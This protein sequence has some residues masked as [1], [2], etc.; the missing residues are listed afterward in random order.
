[1]STVHLCRPHADPR[2]MRGQVVPA[3]AP[4][5]IARLGLFIVQVEPLMGRINIST[6]RAVKLAA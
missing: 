3:L 2:E 1:M 5:E 4:V 6:L